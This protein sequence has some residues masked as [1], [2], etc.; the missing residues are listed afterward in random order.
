MD[1]RDVRDYKLGHISGAVSLP[2]Q[3]LDIRI[4]GLLV[5]RAQQGGQYLV[6]IAADDPESLKAIQLLNDIGVPVQHY[7]EGGMTAWLEA[8]EDVA[9]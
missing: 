6:V 9:E 1:I 8:G 7:L 3:Q 5:E 4:T 2:L